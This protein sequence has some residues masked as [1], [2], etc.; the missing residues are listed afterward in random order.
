MRNKAIY[1]NITKCLEDSGYHKNWQQWRA[2]VKNLKTVY[3]KIKDNN[4]QSE[5]AQ[6]ACPFFEQLDVILGSQPTT[7][8]LEVLESLRDATGTT[9]VLVTVWMMKE[10]CHQQ[11]LMKWNR[12]NPFPNQQRMNQN[13]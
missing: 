7:R 8:P 12:M 13:K 9:V 4:D 10:K 6:G 3:K 2:K 11:R 5:R 1:E